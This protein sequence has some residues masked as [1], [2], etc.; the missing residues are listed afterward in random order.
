MSQLGKYTILAQQVYLSPVNSKLIYEKNLGML[1]GRKSILFISFPE[2]R[3]QVL[4]S[5]FQY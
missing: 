3:H 2:K 5:N 1:V 4:V